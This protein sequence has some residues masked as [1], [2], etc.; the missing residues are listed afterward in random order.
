VLDVVL[1]R[2]VM[3]TV[4]AILVVVAI[5]ERFA[6]LLVTLP[7]HEVLQQIDHPRHL[8]ACDVMVRGFKKILAMHLCTS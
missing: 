8:R 4:S 2:R 5:E 6:L 3:G 7:A 1:L